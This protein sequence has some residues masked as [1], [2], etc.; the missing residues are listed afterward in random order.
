MSQILR[1]LRFPVLRTKVSTPF[2]ARCASH[3]S[4]QNNASLLINKCTCLTE[5]RRWSS[6]SVIKG[7]TPPWASKISLAEI[8]ER[9]MKA[10]SSHDKINAEKLTLDSHFVNDLGLD[11]LDHVEIIMAMEDEFGFEIPDLYSEKLM[12]PKDII[13]F[14]ADKEDVYE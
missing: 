14:V 9:V 6:D 5:Q 3:L 8:E 4:R 2:S 13:Q 12:T 10:C 7:Y 1:R 11:S